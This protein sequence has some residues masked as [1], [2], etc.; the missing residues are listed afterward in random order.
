M[1]IR[2]RFGLAA[3]S[4]SHFDNALYPLRTPHAE[5]LPRYSQL[6]EVAE[7]TILSHRMPGRQML[8]DWIAQTPAGFEFLP[9]MHEAVTHK[10]GGLEMA[11]TYLQLLQP[12]RDAKKLGPVLLQFPASLTHE[13][14]FDLV[15]DLLRLGEPGCFA[16]EVRNMGWYTDAFRALLEDHEAALVW[17]TFP[18]AFAP[19]WNTSE[20]GYIRFTGKVM[21]LR[22]RYITQADRLTDVLEMRKRVEQATWKEAYC[23]V[24]N[25]FEGNA[26]DSMPRIVGALTDADNGKRYMHKPGETLL[27]DPPGYVPPP[28]TAKPR[29]SS[30][31]KAPPATDGSKQTTLDHG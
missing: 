3:W 24:T 17:G 30:R 26:V 16:V 2:F 10:G 31:K 28:E 14:G 21:D 27:K 7:A 15:Q 13:K 1:R 8:E 5:Y 29:K 19:P 25:P 4:N 23:I 9:K 12:L 22:G 6:F 11:K 18:K 20:K